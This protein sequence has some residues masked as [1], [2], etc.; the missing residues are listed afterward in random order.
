MVEI[1]EKLNRALNY[2]RKNKILDTTA[3]SL[4][5][6]IP[7]AGPFLNEWYQNIGIK[8][9]QKVE[10]IILFLERISEKNEQDFNR[11]VMVINE[12]KKDLIENNKML[13]DIYN[14]FDIILSRLEEIPTRKELP[15]IMQDVI[16]KEL[17]DALRHEKITDPNSASITKPSSKLINK[18]SEIKS[19]DEFGFTQSSETYYYMGLTALSNRDFEE[20]TRFF[21]TAL[22]IDPDYTEPYNALS[23]IYQMKGNEALHNPDKSLYYL[24]KA[25]EYSRNA[26]QIN[27]KN[28]A[29]LVQLG[30]VYKDFAQRAQINKKQSEDALNKSKGLFEVVIE[31]DK[32]NAGAHNGLG[33]IY[34][35]T[36]KFDEAV[37]EY[38]KAINLMPNYTF[39]HHDLAI[40]YYKE[41]KI[42]HKQE[43]NF[44]KSAMEEFEIVLRL[45]SSNPVFPQEY[46]PKIQN[47]IDYLSS[48][49][50]QIRPNT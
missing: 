9:T 43:L 21:E 47:L 13:T 32:N 31:H 10:E 1:K 49:I 18:Y 38:K 36:K 26:L 48:I 25:E 34:A 37:S 14:N 35:L 27:D 30:Y 40:A 23:F 5:S 41:M 33:N 6:E 45:N 46:I 19:V 3:K 17:R 24:E 2:I 12:N 4:L 39:A 16:R 7:I 11:L 28:L 44:A 8:D 20:A 29:T 22:H 50:N 42:N 15:T